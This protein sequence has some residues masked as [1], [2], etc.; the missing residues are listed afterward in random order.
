MSRQSSTASSREVGA[1]PPGGQVVTVR[2]HPSM[3]ILYGQSAA[4]SGWRR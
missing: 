2:D 4:S 1:R 3:R